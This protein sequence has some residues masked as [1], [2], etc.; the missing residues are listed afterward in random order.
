MRNPFKV[1][2]LIKKSSLVLKFYLTSLALKRL[3]SAL[4]SKLKL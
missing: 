1:L 4:A 2:A 3:L